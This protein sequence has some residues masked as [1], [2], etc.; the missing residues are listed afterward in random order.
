MS[1]LCWFVSVVISDLIYVPSIR[2]LIFG[3]GSVSVSFKDSRGV[4][5]RKALRQRNGNFPLAI[6]TAFIPACA[7]Y[8]LS[9]SARFLLCHSYCSSITI[10]PFLLK[11][12][13]VHYGDNIQ[14]VSK[15]PRISSQEWNTPS[16]ENNRHSK[17]QAFHL[18]RMPH[19]TEKVHIKMKVPFFFKVLV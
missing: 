12:D 14:S 1:P 16:S 7:S 3:R 18:S 2:S 5:C 19:L 11:R 8:F 4:P 10:V 15:H 13:I 17:V 6:S 9:S